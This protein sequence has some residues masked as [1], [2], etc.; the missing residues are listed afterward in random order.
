VLWPRADDAFDAIEAWLEVDRGPVRTRLGRQWAVG[1]LGVFNY[2]GAS[3]ML[4]RGRAR[5]EAIGGRSLVAGLNEPIAGPELGAIDDL[6][7]DENGWLL[8]LSAS[9]PIGSRGTAGATWQRVIRAD[10]AGLYSERVAA[11]GSWRAFGGSADVS[12]AWDV[13][14]REVNEASLRLARPLRAGLSATL[15][16]RR[17]RPFFEAWTIWGAFS[18]V[19]FD[20][21]R[22]G[23]SW[24]RA[25]G[26]L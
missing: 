3:L 22:A 15:E 1:G 12:L 13:S 18:P 14:A 25:T 23:V 10:R 21:A 8:G 26:S 24:R 11:D 2:D 19:A 16:A 20:E 17:H 7:P 4:R 9:A 5:L 6:P